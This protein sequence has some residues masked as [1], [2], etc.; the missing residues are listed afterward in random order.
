MTLTILLNSFYVYL[1][2]GSGRSLREL[3]K[4]FDIPEHELRGRAWRERWDERIPSLALE[5]LNTWSLPV[6]TRTCQQIHLGLA[7]EATTRMGSV[8]GFRL[9]FTS[10]GTQLLVQL[11]RPQG[12]S[13]P[14]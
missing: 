3:S 4:R 2:M 1:A 8:P 14:A 9:G 6:L 5:I 10:L 12:P 7:L 11:Q 13:V